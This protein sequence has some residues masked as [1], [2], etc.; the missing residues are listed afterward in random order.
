MNALR[1][2]SNPFAECIIRYD[3][4]SFEWKAQ[5]GVWVPWWGP[6]DELVTRA[7]IT[8]LEGETREERNARQDAAFQGVQPP[9]DA[10]N[11]FD[12]A[13]NQALADL[14]IKGNRRAF[15]VWLDFMRE[16]KWNALRST[17]RHLVTGLVWKAG[18]KFGRAPAVVESELKASE[19]EPGETDVDDLPYGPR[20]LDL[21]DKSDAECRLIDLALDNAFREAAACFEAAAHSFFGSDASPSGAGALVEAMP[22]RAKWLPN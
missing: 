3:H 21:N 2:T 4:L 9:E 14:K 7:S 17:N 10:I 18:V 11:S 16:R 5:N 19:P 6:I 12:S 8:H 1:P 13:A 15:E 20:D 22:T